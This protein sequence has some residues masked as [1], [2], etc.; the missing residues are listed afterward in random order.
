MTTLYGWGPM[1]GL[2]SPSPFVMKADIQLQM[3][4]IAFN[5][6]IAD[7]ESVSKHKAPYVE[8]DGAI[9]QDSTFIR[10]HFEK[11]LRGDLDEGLSD[12]G[13]ATAWAFERMLE[14]RLANIE[15]HE[16]WLE[17]DNFDRGPA[18]FFMGV[19]E[20][21]RAQ[22]AAGAVAEFRSTMVANGIGRHSR[23]ERMQLAERDIAATSAL[24]GNKAFMLAGHPTALD[25]A[26]FGVISACAA[27]IFETRLK[28]MVASHANLVAYL[29][30]ME[31]RFFAEDRWPSMM[32][33]HGREAAA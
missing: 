2:Q 27:P 14:D 25:A 18:M 7:L 24:L 26:A 30:R 12:A 17:G 5:R 20:Q 32:P 8:D 21:M 6:A 9:I 1:F 16:R 3:F 31:A 4:D 29:E 28:G 19:P 33:E 13:R 15:G 22:I 23:E 10:W 11:K